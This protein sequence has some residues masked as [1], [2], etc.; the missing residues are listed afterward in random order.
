MVAALKAHVFGLSWLQKHTRLA[1][2]MP[3]VIVLVAKPAKL[4]LSLSFAQ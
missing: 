3:D 1:V 2:S 4:K